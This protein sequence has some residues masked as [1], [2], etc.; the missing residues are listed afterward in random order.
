M[1]KAEEW[2]DVIVTMELSVAM[3]KLYG[4]KSNKTLRAC[5]LALSQRVQDDNIRQI[6]IAVA[7]QMYPEGALAMIR[8]RMDELPE[9]TA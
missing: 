7:K 1:E 2:L 8:R 3:A 4:D 9:D 5:C 6:L